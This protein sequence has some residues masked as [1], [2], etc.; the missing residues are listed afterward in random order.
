[1]KWR[2]GITTLFVI[3]G[4]LTV[5]HF[6]NSATKKTNTVESTRMSRA[7]VFPTGGWTTVDCSNVAAASSAALTANTR[8][9][10]QCTDDSYIAWGTAAT[11]QDADSSDGYV[12]DGSWLEFLTTDTIVYYSC[13]NINSDADCRHIECQ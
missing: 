13:L 3:V 9:V 10:V 12:P 1:M 5:A 4:V 11:G 2:H 7:C 8:Y 6:A